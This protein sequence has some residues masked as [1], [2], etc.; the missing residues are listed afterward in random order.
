M[1]EQTKRL[2]TEERLKTLEA[3]HRALAGE[4]DDIRRHVN[5]LREENARLRTVR[6]ATIPER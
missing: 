5:D 4:L 1:N 6:E 3:A 2:T